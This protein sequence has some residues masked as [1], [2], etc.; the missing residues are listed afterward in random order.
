MSPM[1]DYYVPARALRKAI[2][3]IT[4]DGNNGL[5][6]PHT[7]LHTTNTLKNLLVYEEFVEAQEV[8]AVHDLLTP[9][10]VR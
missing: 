3:E 6:D 2:D 9:G 5:L 10:V 8:P 1:S 7:A 4:R